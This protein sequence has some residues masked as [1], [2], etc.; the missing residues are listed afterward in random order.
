[1]TTWWRCCDTSSLFFLNGRMFVGLV[2]SST[3]LF[4]ATLC[5]AEPNVAADGLEFQLPPKTSDQTFIYHLCVF[6]ILWLCLLMTLRLFTSCPRDTKSVKFLLLQ[7]NVRIKMHHKNG[8]QWKTTSNSKLKACL[9]KDVSAA[10]E[11]EFHHLG[12]TA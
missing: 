5:K 9:S 10:F 7:H 4:P 11:R 12:A 8:K 6:V 2:L 3:D 1:M